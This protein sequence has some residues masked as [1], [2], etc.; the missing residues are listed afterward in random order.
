MALSSAQFLRSIVSAHAT[1]AG[2]LHRLGVEDGSAR[3]G[4]TTCARA[5]P[6][7][8]H[9]VD[10]LPGAVQAPHPEVVVH[11]RPRR[12]LTWKHAPLAAASQEV[13]DGV[14]DLA[15]GP[16]ARTPSELGGRDKWGED[17]PFWVRT[18]AGIQAK[19]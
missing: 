10:L 13:E 1:D 11:R 19:R 6:F 8:Q 18:I 12:E 2:S 9:R 4:I 17:L 3:L 15:R 16:L 5:Y 14:E 7:A